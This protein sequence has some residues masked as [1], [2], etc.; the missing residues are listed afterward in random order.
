MKPSLMILENVHQSRNKNSVK[1]GTE[2][3]IAPKICSLV[4]ETIINCESLRSFKQKIGKWK[5][6]W[7]CRLYK[8][9]LQNADFI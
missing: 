4:T 3:Y 6:D 8:V 1:Y 2:N 9:Y 5:T 7:P